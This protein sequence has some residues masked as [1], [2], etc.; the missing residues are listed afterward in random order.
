MEAYEK[1]S[2]TIKDRYVEAL[3]SFDTDVQSA[4]DLALQRYL[5]D[6]ITVRI[7]NLKKKD[8]AFQSKYGCDYEAFAR[9]TAADEGYVKAVEETINRL[10]EADQA[11][12]E[13]CRKGIDDWTKKLQTI[14]LTS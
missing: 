13:F 1:D 10:W 8:Q 2:I 7:A 12:W 4:V 9:R 14:L 3:S 5:I 6:Q 11:D